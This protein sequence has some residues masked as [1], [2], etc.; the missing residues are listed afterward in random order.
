MS[1]HQKPD[2][3]EVTAAA[4]KQLLAKGVSI[5]A[6]PKVLIEFHELIQ[7]GDYGRGIEEAVRDVLAT[8][9]G[10]R[11]HRFTDRG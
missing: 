7:S 9:P 11:P 4:L 1:P 6:Q 5:P 3:P 2:Q 10:C 8:G